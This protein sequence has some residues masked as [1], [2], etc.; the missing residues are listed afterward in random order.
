MTNKLKNVVSL[1]IDIKH[2]CGV[3]QNQKL[4]YVTRRVA[5]CAYQVSALLLNRNL[6]ISVIFILNSNYHHACYYYRYYYCCCHFD[7]TLKSGTFG[8]QALVLL[9]RGTAWRKSRTSREIRD[10]WQPYSKY[11]TS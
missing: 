5:H 11:V 10:G 3:I 9:G 7:C 2:P 1:I 4:T 8:V 6:P